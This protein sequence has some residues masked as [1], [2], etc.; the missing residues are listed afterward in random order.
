MFPKP[1]ASVVYSQPSV[2]ISAGSLIKV[3]KGI[4]GLEV[5]KAFSETA[6]S[7][8]TP[9]IMSSMFQIKPLTAESLSI[10]PLAAQTHKFGITT[11]EKPL[12]SQTMGLG[13]STIQ[14]QASGLATPNVPVVPQI[15]VPEFIP[16]IT[17][18]MT[19]PIT[20]FPI[21]PVA[22]LFPSLKLF[23]GR[24]K[25]F[26]RA[27]QPFKYQASLGGVLSG[28]YSMKIPKGITTGIMPVRWMIGE[29]KKRKVK[30]RKLKRDYS[31]KIKIPKIYLSKTKFYLPKPKIK[32][33][34]YK[35]KRKKY[36][37][38]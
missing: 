23:K 31:L 12:V 10:S 9:V 16:P 19:F 17:P 22:P 18:Q 3:H 20:P 21:I 25:P 34:K 14:A 8:T 29:S 7:Y 38:R 13:L 30:P 1:S 37:K 15:E 24:K 27:K 4:I 35:K 33:R 36:A 5:G 6:M 32:L 28:E 2:S 11:I 26:I